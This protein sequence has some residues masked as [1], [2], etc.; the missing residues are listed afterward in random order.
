MIK[1]ISTLCNPFCICIHQIWDYFRIKRRK[2]FSLFLMLAHQDCRILLQDYQIPDFP[3]I[4]NIG[5]TMLFFDVK[6][7]VL[8]DFEPNEKDG[9]LLFF[10]LSVKD[11]IS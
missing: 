6:T 10:S 3:K 1:Q 9:C 7:F 4:Y 2:I 5:L 8:I 11:G